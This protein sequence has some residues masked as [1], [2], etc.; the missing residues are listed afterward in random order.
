LAAILLFAEHHTVALAKRHVQYLAL[1]WFRVEGSWVEGL[2]CWSGL[3]DAQLNYVEQV[4]T[5]CLGCLAIGC[6]CVNLMWAERLV[7]IMLMVCWC[8]CCTTSCWQLTHT[9][10]ASLAGCPQ[11]TQQAWWHRPGT[12]HVFALPASTSALWALHLLAG[13]LSLHALSLFPCVVQ[14]AERVGIDAEK[15]AAARLAAARAS[16]LTEVSPPSPPPGALPPAA[17]AAASLMRCMCRAPTPHM[18]TCMHVHVCSKTGL[19]HCALPCGSRTSGKHC[20]RQLTH[21]SGV[22]LLK[23]DCADEWSPSAD[24]NADAR[25]S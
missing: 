1:L 7:A 6:E 21:T 15:L 8:R 19:L 4:G 3:A 2:G 22:R 20:G 18:H 9:H 23:D 25:K 24:T 16:S 14:H 13:P 5:P 12:Q 11:P 10:T 17:A